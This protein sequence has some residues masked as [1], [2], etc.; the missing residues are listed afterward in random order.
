M[1]YFIAFIVGFR[2]PAIFNMK[3]YGTTV[4]NNFQSLP[5]FCHKELHLRCC[6]GR[7]LN[8]VTSFTKIL[9]DIG[10]HFSLPPHVRVQLWENIKNTPS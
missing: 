9:K 2:N 7:A 1:Q 10:A 3:L 8:F 5:I 4:N 6:I